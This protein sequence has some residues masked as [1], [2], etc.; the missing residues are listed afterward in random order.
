MSEQHKLLN[1]ASEFVTCNAQPINDTMRRRFV[2][3][4]DQARAVELQNL[5]TWLYDD[6]SIRQKAQIMKLGRE[7]HKIHIALRRSGR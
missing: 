3:L 6:S 7:L 5:G 4:S 1:W 2:H